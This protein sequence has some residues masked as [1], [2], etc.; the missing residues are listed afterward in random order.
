MKKYAIFMFSALL[1]FATTMNAQ[2]NKEKKAKGPSIE[3]RVEKMA[4]DLGLSNVEKAT[5][6]TLLEKQDAEKKQFM[7]DTDKES[8]DFKPKMKELQKKQSAELKA[9]IGDEKFQKLQT[10]KAEEKKAEKKAE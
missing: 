8:A 7:K 1:M 10:L 2:E 4:T 5:V 3:V 6:K 9:A